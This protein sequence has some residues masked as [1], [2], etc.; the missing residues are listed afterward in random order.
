MPEGQKD[1]IF[2]VLIAGLGIGWLTGLSVSPVVGTVLAGI[3]TAVAGVV[4][5]VASAGTDAARQRVN[6]W[7]LAI[8][9]VGVAFGGPLG[10][11]A[12]SHNIFGDSLHVTVATTGATAGLKGQTTTGAEAMSVLFS[13]NADDCGRLRGS[14]DQSLAGAL[15]TSR[16]DWA[17]R[18]ARRS[19]DPKV[20]RGVVEFVCE[21]RSHQ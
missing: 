11:V 17:Q 15:E 16:M 14:P 20:M 12:R 4:A 8:L 19:T 10:I 2:A 21:E 5:G 18:L 7:P 13:A 9:V 3:M 6:A 1:Q